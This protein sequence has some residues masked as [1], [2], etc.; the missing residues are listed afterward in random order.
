VVDRRC[1]VAASVRQHVGQEIAREG[2]VGLRVSLA[3]ADQIDE[4][5]AGPPQSWAMRALGSARVRC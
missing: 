2:R 1:H 3:F 5:M 4:L